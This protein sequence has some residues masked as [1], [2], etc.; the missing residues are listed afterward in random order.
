MST[1]FQA[2]NHSQWTSLNPKPA[3]TLGLHPSLWGNML[4]A[5]SQNALCGLFFED[6]SKF[7]QEKVLPE[8]RLRWPGSQI[9]FDSQS[10]AHWVDIAI[11]YLS[12][13]PLDPAYSLL[14]LGTPFQIAVWSALLQIPF[15]KVVSY[16]EIAKRVGRPDACRAVGSAIGKNKISILVPCHRVIQSSGALGG[17]AWGLP[18]KESLIDFEKKSLT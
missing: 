12:G 8:A 14:L 2:K 17:Y 5:Q 15:G 6:T 9:T 3:I 11:S 13:I 4:I 10:T 18:L 16:K 7:D 1:Y